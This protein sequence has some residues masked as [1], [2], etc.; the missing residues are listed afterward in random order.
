MGMGTGIDGDRA[1]T[2]EAMVGC[3]D[4]AFAP[5]LK[6]TS[7]WPALTVSAGRAGPPA[8]PPPPASTAGT[9]ALGWLQKARVQCQVVTANQ[10]IAGTG[11]GEGSPPRSCRSSPRRLLPTRRRNPTWLLARPR[12]SVRALGGSWASSSLMH[13]GEQRGQGGQQGPHPHPRQNSHP[14][15]LHPHLLQ[16]CRV[17][18][19]L[20]GMGTVPFLSPFLRPP[21]LPLR[22]HPKSKPSAGSQALL[23][24]Q[25]FLCNV[26]SGRAAAEPQKP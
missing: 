10:D 19:Q 22:C 15:R 23:E 3:T 20:Q 25:D 26:W 2:M 12:P 5:G 16:C 1:M 21:H 11:F 4:G 8:G 6:A 9:P 17:S 18:I 24:P 7:F 13:C 14:H